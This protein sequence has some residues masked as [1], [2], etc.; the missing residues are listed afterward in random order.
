MKMQIASDFGLPIE[1][2]TETFCVLARRG[3]GKT[4]SASVMAEE[5][6]KAKQQI[7]A[8]DPT[9]SWWGLR[10][11]FPIVIMGG[12]H[13]DVPIEETAGEVI[14]QAIVENR[15]SAVID[16]SL[17][18]KGQMIRFMVPFAETLYRLN[19]EPV[20]L[21]VDEADQFAPQ[22]RNWG[23]EENRML[24]AMEDIVRR[25]R[26]RGIGC[27][28][29]TQRPSVLNKNVLTQAGS[30]FAMRMGH[31]RDIDAIQEWIDVH[32]EVAESKEVIKSL[33][34]LPIGEGWLWSPGWLG[35]LKRIKIRKRE[36]FDSSATPKPGE[37]IKEPRTLAQVNLDQLGEQIKATVERAKANDPKALKRLLAEKDKR[38]AELERTGGKE[39][40]V[41]KIVEVPV[42]KNGQLT[43][44]EGIVERVD[45]IAQKMLAEV[46][47]LKKLVAPAFAPKAPVIAVRT[48][49]V[50]KPQVLQRMA[51]TPKRIAR[52]AD[53]GTISKVQQRILDAIAWYESLG[54]AE[55]TLTQIGA[56]A[57]IDPSGGYFSN[58]VGPLSATG[59]VD[60]GH[61]SIRLTDAGRAMA[62]VP[63]SVGTL[64]DY[65][66]IL[67]ARVRRM[68]S[69]S[70]KTIEM[71]H[72]IIQAGGAAVSVD[73]VG[74]AVG[75][76]HTGGYFSNCIG[77][78]STVGLIER[79]GGV[80]TPTDVLF[81]PG[82]R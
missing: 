9:G 47:E 61:G 31:P 40:T 58:V 80:V 25:G 30:L 79:R 34:S 19:R 29:I 21:F 6:L 70:G 3:A 15:F 24:G 12:E 1:S 62:T 48:L 35:I 16:L 26:K 38:I 57:L 64:A 28:L 4:Y 44:M 56:V 7:V 82:L 10:S 36:T 49:V 51:A 69:A 18:R 54:N 66:D 13:A 65:H 27:T 22:G 5:M 42:L 41:E 8:L 76:D 50:P 39:T 14:A 71:L 33:P 68:K 72:A 60:R 43:R 73:D 2:V 78:L 37:T 20:H 53:D 74:Q 59:L 81:P 46:G 75:I 17:F 63:E 67:R 32:A 23:G 11:G 45:A 55:P 77:P 52:P